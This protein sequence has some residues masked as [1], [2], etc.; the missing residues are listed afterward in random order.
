MTDQLT[1][2]KP[3]A[4]PTPDPHP[5]TR[6]GLLLPILI[7]LGSFAIIGVVLFGFSRVLLS[8]T[9]H[10]ATAVALIVAVS[11]M[12]VAIVV[13][14]RQRLSNG[15]L[16]SMVGS[17]AGIAMLAG[18]LAIVTIGA[19]EGEG[20]GGPQVVTLAAPKGA[21][22]T[23]FDPTSLSVV[24]NEPIELDFSN[25]DP[26]IQHNVVIFP[27]D[28]TKNPDAKE[29]FSGALVTGAADVKY[30]VPPLPPGTLF[31]HCVVHPTTMI[32]TI[33]S[34]EGGG[35]GGGGGSGGGGSTTT[36]VAKDLTFDTDQLNLIAGQPTTLTFDNE[37]AGVPHNIAIYSDDSL[38]ETLFQGTQFPGIATEE[39][40]IPAL[41][42]GTYYFHCDVHTT[43]SGSVVVGPAG[44]SGPGGEPPPDATG[45][46]GPSG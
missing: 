33:D 11:V 9:P 15:A 36:V 35:E 8:I 46:T 42:A 6:Q 1:N 32:G 16:F 23:G 4:A 24:A 30:D 25:Q 31:F 18:G 2:E 19:G 5:E 10:A 14:S 40:Q 38:A 20:G 39:Y 43:M 37:D 27:E 7:P 21:A 41:D 45:A 13:A 29:V 17:I 44:G 34:A 22:A 3:A 12:V 26:G 28:P